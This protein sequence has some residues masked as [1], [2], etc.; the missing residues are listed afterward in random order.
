M[1]TSTLFTA[2]PLRFFP[3]CTMVC[4]LP[5]SD[6]VI[7]LVVVTCPSNLSTRSIVFVVNLPKRNGGMAI[8]AQRMIFSV[9]SCEHLSVSRLPSWTNAVADHLES[10]FRRRHCNFKAAAGGR[11][12]GTVLRFCGV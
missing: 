1:K 2:S 9:K 12:S 4:V 10:A 11:W 6:T 7:L 8:I 3:V 5:P